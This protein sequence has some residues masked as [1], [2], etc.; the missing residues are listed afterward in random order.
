[1][2]KDTCEPVYDEVFDY[3]LDPSK[4]SMHSLEASVVD[5]KGIF[6][7]SPL[8]GRTVVKLDDPAIYSGITEW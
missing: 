4:L 3:D 6:A 2:I 5:R 7:K 8:M 1:M